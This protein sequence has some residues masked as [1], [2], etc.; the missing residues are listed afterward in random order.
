MSVNK[1]QVT[2]ENGRGPSGQEGWLWELFGSL[3]SFGSGQ[4]SQLYLS[5]NIIFLCPTKKI[6]GLWIS[7]YS[8]LGEL[9]SVLFHVREK[10]TCKYGSKDL[11]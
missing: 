2:G 5:F 8:A 10:A 7:C 6:F 1:R 3:I 9:G 4:Q 11:W